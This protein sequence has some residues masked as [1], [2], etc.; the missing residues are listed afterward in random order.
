M[1]SIEF[2]FKN[3]D[4]LFF[5]ELK[6]KQLNVGIIEVDKKELKDISDREKELYISHIVDID[7]D[8]LYKMETNINPRS[9]VEI[10][11]F[12]NKSVYIYCDTKKAK[13][14]LFYNIYK[15]VYDIKL[16]FKIKI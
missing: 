16:Q 6:E 9:L 13:D 12:I 4:Y 7:Y 10:I 3:F 11:K 5:M 15:K 1:E 8:V 14:F 2:D